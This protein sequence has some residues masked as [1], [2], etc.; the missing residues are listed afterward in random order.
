[1]GQIRGAHLYNLDSQLKFR[2]PA[3]Y[4][5]AYTEPKD[6]SIWTDSIVGES[7]KVRTFLLGEG[8][9]ASG[10]LPIAALPFIGQSGPVGALVLLLQESTK[11]LPFS[12]KD[13]FPIS[14]LGALHL[15]SKAVRAEILPVNRGHSADDITARQKEILE[16]M[17]QGMTNAEIAD[18]ILLSE[19]T[20][21][22]ETIRIYRSLSVPNRQEAI[23]KAKDIGL[24]QDQRFLV[25]A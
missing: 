1:M 18:E 20:V 23:I 19:S 17:A 22:Q 3:G 15:K 7:F 5:H 13:F 12:A 24:I 25:D 21:R 6:F 11:S 14:R 16:F 10:G 8:T 2:K 4:G 9:P